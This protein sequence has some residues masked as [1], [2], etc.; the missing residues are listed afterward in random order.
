MITYINTKNL[1]PHPNN[2]RQDLGDLTELME[3]IKVRGVLQNLTVVPIPDTG[4][5]KVVIG[6]RRLAAAVKAGLEELPCAVVEM[7][8]RTQIG[9]MLLENIQR[10][11]LTPYEQAAGIQMMFDLGETAGGIAEKT[12]FSETTI[13][14]RVKLLELDKDEFKKAQKRGATLLD[15]A[16]LEKIEDRERKN[17]ALKS[18][19]TNNFTWK[20][21][22]AIDEEKRLRYAAEAAKA[23]DTFA[24]KIEQV[25]Y[26]IMQY[27]RAY[28]TG[29]AIEKPDDAGE[30]KYY[31]T[32]GYGPYL[33]K[34][35]D[36][37]TINASIISEQER[38]KAE[39]R[40][41]ALHEKSEAA[42]LLRREF[43][44]GFTKAKKHACDI[45]E[46]VAQM[47][48][49]SYTN[50]DSDEVAEMLGLI[51]AEGEWEE[52]D[53]DQA[54]LDDPEKAALVAVYSALDE[55]REYF[56]YRGE[57]QPNENLDAVYAFLARLGYQM[58]DEEKALKDGTHE[59][60]KWEDTQAE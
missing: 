42:H 51:N 29:E 58:S 50:T 43:I 38:G 35:R 28:S 7:D 20:I 33:Y 23:L 48:V 31:Y 60:F 6:H 59:L 14:R 39:E 13:R 49:E 52:A 21:K 56:N 22:N 41:A 57:Y 12:G 30:A 11:D 24:T 34:E 53:L 25:D 47:L 1:L 15:F 16:E 36:K 10:A 8:E 4:D 5:Y 18:I 54:I 19:G 46:K 44:I 3:S 32:L 45:L 17:E 37:E 55:D 26:R 40:K 27:V 9:T 2:P